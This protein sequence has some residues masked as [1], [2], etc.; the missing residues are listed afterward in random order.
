MGHHEPVYRVDIRQ[1]PRSSHEKAVQL[2]VG[3][4]SSVRD[5][6]LHSADGVGVSRHAVD[7]VVLDHAVVPGDIHPA[8]V[9][10]EILRLKGA[11]PGEE[12]R[13]GA[14][15]VLGFL[16]GD[17]AHVREPAERRYVREIS[18]VEPANVH[19]EEV[20]LGDH[21]GGF[22]HVLGDIQRGGEIVD[23]SR[24]DI[25]A[26]YGKFPGGNSVNQFVEHS[27]AAGAYYQVEFR[28]AL[29]DEFKGIP[30]AAGGM[31]HHVVSACRESRKDI[32]Q[33]RFHRAFSGVGIIGEQ[34]FLHA[35]AAFP[36]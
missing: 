6:V 19:G 30:G 33:R 32:R 20:L 17:V 14:Q 11:Q 8:G 3:E 26:W 18:A 34:Q 16:T 12:I 15:A 22:P 25:T 23:R 28:A 1:I 35:T 31:H 13:E 36:C 2:S 5:D 10:L 29:G 9:F 21:F 4:G 24:G 7:E 27:V